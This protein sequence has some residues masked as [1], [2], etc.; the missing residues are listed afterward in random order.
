M[1]IKF[2]KFLL[3]GDGDAMR[4][5]APSSPSRLAIDGQTVIQIDE[6]VRGEHPEYRDRGNRSVALRFTSERLHR[7]YGDAEIFCLTHN[8]ELPA[9]EKMVLIGTRANGGKVQRVCE[10]A[11]RVGTQTSHVGIRTTTHYT[12]LLGEL[13]EARI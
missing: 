7:S 5:G 2:G 8:D 6:F 11:A 3:A 4:E 1:E 12:F 9:V 10:R 13:K